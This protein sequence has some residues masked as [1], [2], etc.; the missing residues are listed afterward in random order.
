VNGRR[1]R[2][3]YDYGYSIAHMENLPEQYKRVEHRLKMLDVDWVEFCGY[4]G[5]GAPLMLYEMVRDTKAGV[6][7]GDKSCTVTA[8]LA[9]AANIPAYVVATWADRPPEAQ[10]EIDRLNARVLDL[11]RLYPVTRIR[12]QQ[13]EP[14]RGETGK[15]TTAGWFDLIAYAHS[16]HHAQCAAAAASG[17]KLANPAW[18]RAADGRYSKSGLWVP[19]HPTLPGM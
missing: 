13:R 4:G 9:R 17:D 14:I 15:F 12:A 6:G 18:L 3:G 5:C 19:V 8:R 16:S 11:T 7:L 10:A 2:F 1:R